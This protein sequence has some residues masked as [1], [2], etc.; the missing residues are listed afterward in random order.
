VYADPTPSDAGPDQTECGITTT[1]LAGNTPVIGTG[2][3]SIVSGAG[4]NIIAPAN[5]TSQFIG[6]NGTAYT[7]RWTISNGTCTSLD[8]VDINFTILPDPPAASSP[9][10]FCGSATI[11]DLVAVPPAGCTVDW[12]NA[13]SG[14]VLLPGATALVD[15]TTY[16]AESNGGGVCVSSTRTAVDV[17]INPLPNP[18]LIGPNSVCIGSTGNIYTTEA[19]KSNYD[20]AVVGGFFTDGGLGTHNTA[21]VTWNVA[22]SQS[23]SVNYDDANGC[24]AASPTAYSVI[25]NEIP[26]ITLGSNPSVCS[27]TTS[28][29]LTYSATSGTPNQYSIDYSGAA[30]G[31]GFADVT[32]IV[33]PA[34]PISLVV[35]GGASAGTYSGDLTVTN[36]ITGCASGTYM[37]NVTVNALPASPTADA[38]TYTYDGLSKTATASVGG[39]ETVDWYAAATGGGTIAAPSGTNTGTYS[40]YAEARN[41]TTGCVSAARTLVTLTIN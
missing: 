37:I 8:D 3:W 2:L 29:N 16:Y 19:G 23:I 38:N 5:P 1:N 24:T 22:G 14:G 32:N 7:L 6:L 30:E 15:A 11:A 10:S 33:L 40:A 21:T 41:T 31:V 34:S 9:Q 17:T 25:V 26:T 27:G 4:G 13:A 39:G 20:W 35:P 18:G 12:Y 36:S 28:A